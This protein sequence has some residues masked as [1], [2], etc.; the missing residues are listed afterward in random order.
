MIPRPLQSVRFRLAALYS[1]LVF[2][3]AGLVVWVIYLAVAHDVHGD[4]V[5]RP[6]RGVL[7]YSKGG[8]FRPVERVDLVTAAQIETAVDGAIL[9]TLR[10]YTLLT[11]L[12]LFL[13]SLV[14][15]WV[16]AGRALRP[17]RRIAE[18]A[19]HISSTDLSRRIRLQGPDDEFHQ[20]ADTLD[21]MLAR[22][23]D[24]FT[25]QRRMLDDAS[26]ELRT[27]L[28]VI[29]AN[30]EGVLLD[31]DASPQERR[32][33]TAVVVRAIGRMNRLVDDLL[34][35]GRRA[36]P[37]FADRPVD[38]ATVVREA[39]EEF[40]QLAERRDLRLRYL[41]EP[42]A[43]VLGDPDA[44]RRAVAN[45]LSNAV[46]LAPPG[47]EVVIG[48]GRLGGWCFAAVRDAGPGLGDEQQQRVFDRFWRGEEPA[49]V[50]NGEQHTGLGLSI[51]RQIVEGHGGQ[52]RLFSRPGSG[53]TFL[54]WLPAASLDAAPR[55][56]AP[57]SADP[58]ALP[59]PA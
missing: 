4:P 28:A 16:L 48:A 3:L 39:G 2:A 10:R 57:P 29:Q 31:E 58:L 36:A 47:T 51:V 56:D 45:L 5:I 42:D 23:D 11:L 49:A 38:L 46:R 35:A 59:A 34:A 52:V 20:L 18:Q 6:V 19:R 30:V 26:H 13:A 44:L 1:I 37:V 12:G 24:A 50:S 22:L 21:S 41:T 32:Q 15:G 40:P 55:S 54:L 8:M 25:A 7:G 9:D 27:P 14:I 33:A 43:I 53:S 17:V